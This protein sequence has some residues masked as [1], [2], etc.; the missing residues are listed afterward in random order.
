MRRFHRVLARGE[1]AA[2]R[3]DVRRRAAPNRLVFHLKFGLWIQDLVGTCPSIFCNFGTSRLRLLLSVVA[4]VRRLAARGDVRRRSAAN[5][6]CYGF[7]I[8]TFLGLP[9]VSS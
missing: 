4:R 2:A 1:R 7:R 5:R 8:G 6:Y 3:G 9:V